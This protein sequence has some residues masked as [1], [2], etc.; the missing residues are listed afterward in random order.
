[1]RKRPMA[2]IPTVK[3]QNMQKCETDGS[4]IKK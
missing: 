1:M 2:S 4:I 3:E